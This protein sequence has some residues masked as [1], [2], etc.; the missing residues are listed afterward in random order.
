M[1]KIKIMVLNEKCIPTR[2]Y[3]GDAGLD[4]RAAKTV[5]IALDEY[6]PVPTG[7]CAE[8]PNGYVGLVCARSGLALKNGIGM[9]NGIGIIDA[10]YRGEIQALLINHGPHYCTIEEGDRIAQLILVPVALPEVEIVKELSDS[11]RGT[12]GFGSTGR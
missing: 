10:G 9:V 12:G 1:Q 7:V 2:A 3:P 5:H 11:E 4:L 6:R 8:I